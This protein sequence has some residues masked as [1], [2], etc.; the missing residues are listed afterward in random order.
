MFRHISLFV[1]EGF[2]EGVLDFN[3]KGC[4][5]RAQGA[6]VLLALAGLANLRMTGRILKYLWNKTSGGI[7]IFLLIAT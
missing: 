3:Q 5:L 1:A 4:E 6:Q 2:I 7:G